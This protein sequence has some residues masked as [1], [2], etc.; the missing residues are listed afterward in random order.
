[1]AL[2]II[3]LSL[4]P[5]FPANVV[6]S[7][8]IVITKAGLTYTFSWDIT[9]FSPNP[10]PNAP[11]VQVL[12]YNGATGATERYPLS[13]IQSG[14][15]ITA[16]QISD[17]TANGRTIITGS[18][19][20]GRTALGL[21]DVAT[22]NA[23]TGLTPD[24]GT[25]RLATSGASAGSYTNASVTVDIYGR[26]TTVTSGATAAGTF[27]Q[28]R[29]VKSGSNIVLQPLNGNQ[30]TINGVNQTIPS[31][32]VS[33]APTGLTPS[34]LYYIYAYMSGGTMT[35]E[36]STTAR[37]TDTSTG[38]QIK[39]GDAT[40]TLV[41]LVR[42]I[43]GPAFADTAAQRF[44]ISWHN[45][46]PIYGSAAFTA[47]RSTSST[48]Y[49]E[50]N[51]EIRNEFVTWSDNSVS[52]AITGSWQ[53]SSGTAQ[54]YAGIAFDGATPSGGIAQSSAT[55]SL[56]L[57]ATVSASLSEGYHYATLGAKV[58]AST[59]L[60]TGGADGSALQTMVRG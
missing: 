8:P 21:G 5:V 55:L 20:A 25:L 1:M 36:A 12:G 22:L 31:A 50:V 34:T 24:S 15:Q 27:G 2:P 16:S 59:V 23:G 44:V 7:D 53:S 19:S 39:T 57:A 51:S 6:G 17:A 3:N 11:Q 40:R 29:L 60:F 41:G 28:C 33:L 58:S 4:L 35:L 56:S 14:L 49:A 42:P 38:V 46:R 18:Q 32:G 45:Q 47:N 10:S 30:L 48:S 13:A 26:V 37:A 52:G 54:N 9:K 43:T